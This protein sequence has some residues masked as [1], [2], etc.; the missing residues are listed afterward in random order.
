MLGAVNRAHCLTS[1]KT[2]PVIFANLDYLQWLHLRDLICLH[3][4]K[5]YCI[6]FELCLITFKKLGWQN[7]I[8]YKRHFANKAFV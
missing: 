6:V 8:K 2:V 1:L 7:S 5:L 4:R 3:H